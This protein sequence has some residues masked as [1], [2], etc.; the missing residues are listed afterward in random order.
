MISNSAM[1]SLENRRHFDISIAV[2]NGDLYI[3]GTSKNDLITVSR[4]TLNSVAL[5]IRVNKVSTIVQET[6]FS[7]FRI[8]GY[9]GNDN[10]RIDQSNGLIPSGANIF[11]AGGDDTLTGGSGNDRIRGDSGHDTIFGGNG[12]D[13]L[14]GDGGDDN[15]TGEGGRDTI[16]GGGGNDMIMGSRGNDFMF[17]EVGDDSVQGGPGDDDVFGGPGIDILNGGAGNDD[18]DLDVS[19]TTD[20]TAETDAGNNAIG[21]PDE[22]F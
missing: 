7:Q 9:N 20:W 22:I 14:Y 21:N 8:Y 2:L 6:E 11:G 13:R 3:E 10:I 17:G 18:F 4:Q 12:A 19:D 5:L 16:Y 15:I 1:E